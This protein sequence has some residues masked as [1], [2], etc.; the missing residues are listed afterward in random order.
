MTRWP[1]A[2]RCK[3][4]LSQTIGA[5]KAAA[6]QRKLI[7]HTIAVAKDLQEKGYLEIQLAVEGIGNKKISRWASSYAI[8]QAGYQ[9]KGSGFAA[10]PNAGWKK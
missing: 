2:I 4:R 6:I 3:K 1:A 8:D 5:S 9:G 7:L 10:I